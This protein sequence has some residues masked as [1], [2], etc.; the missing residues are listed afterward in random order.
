MSHEGGG[1]IKSS[2]NCH[3][4]FQWLRQTILIGECTINVY[5]LPKGGESTSKIDI[6]GKTMQNN[7]QSRDHDCPKTFV[8]GESK[9]IF[10][11]GK[12]ILFP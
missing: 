2:K 6:N 5:E 11:E 10:L 7:T 3:I 8:Q 9:I 1:G 4:L 12:N